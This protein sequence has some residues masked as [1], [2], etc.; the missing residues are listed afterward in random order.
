MNVKKIIDDDYLDHPDLP[1]SDVKREIKI[2]TQLEWHNEKGHEF[3]DNLITVVMEHRKRGKKL[4]EDVR[5][6]VSI[7]EYDKAEKML[8]EVSSM[9]NYLRTSKLLADIEKEINIY[10]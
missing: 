10:L 1:K 2:L 8:A 7:R 9:I 6:L 4:V 5:K 3:C